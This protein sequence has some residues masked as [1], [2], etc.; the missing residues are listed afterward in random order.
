MHGTG[1]DLGHFSEH[2]LGPVFDLNGPIH[3]S[4]NL[5]VNE[6]TN[7]CSTLIVADSTIRNISLS[8]LKENVSEKGEKIIVRRHPGATA[9][10]MSFFIKDSLRRYK[11][12]RLII[13]GG[14]N[15]V[16]FAS[17]NNKTE[18][19]IV[20]SIMRMADEGRKSGCEN[21]FVSS[22]LPRGGSGWNRY[23]EII[24]RVNDM[25]K[26]LCGVHDFFFLDHAAVSP[27]HICRDG[28][29][30]N[31]YG[32]TILK[33]NILSCFK[34]FNPYLTSFYDEYLAAFT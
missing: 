28:I 9:D 31:R 12:K 15:D 20:N 11:P 34:G 19:D 16:S 5:Q 13:F 27:R 10:E 18:Y 21:V 22:V 25:L 23:E 4:S 14:C 24:N 33:M 2:T 1:K 8:Q 17:T 32:T 6:N 29:H 3:Q 7:K 30:P 26:H